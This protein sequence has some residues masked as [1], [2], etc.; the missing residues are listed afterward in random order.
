MRVV[1]WG[2]LAA[3]VA[4]LVAGCGAGGSAAKRSPSAAG[5]TGTTGRASAVGAGSRIDVSSVQD[6]LRTLVAQQTGADVKSVS[7]PSLATVTVGG[8]LTCRATGADG[9]TASVAMTIK[10]SRGD[11][12]LRPLALLQTSSAAKL[13]A[14]ALTHEY[15]TPVGVECPDLVSAHKNTTMTCHATAAGSLHNVI[16]TVKDD[17]G[18]LA[19]RLQ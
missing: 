13:I 18:S 17:Q 7:C 19:Y 15:K 1:R 11:V 6:K 3:V 10:D 4:V 16:V 2:P 14:D 5:T 12:A 9:T 8:E